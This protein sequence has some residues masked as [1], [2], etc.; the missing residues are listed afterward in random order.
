MHNLRF[1]LLSGWLMSAALSPSFAQPPQAEPARQPAVTPWGIS[2]SASSFRN[3][4][5][6]FPKMKAAGVS[7]VRLFPE[8]RGFEPQSGTW[9]W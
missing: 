2:S 4:E 9:Q 7:T 8:W 6:W 1:Y 3:H 5:E